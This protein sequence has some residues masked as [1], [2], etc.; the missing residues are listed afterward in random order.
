[1]KTAAGILSRSRFLLFCIAFFD[2]F[3]T[4]EGVMMNKTG[5]VLEGG[6]MRGVYTAGVLDFFLDRSLSFSCCYGASAGAANAC[7]FLSRQRRRGFEIMGD[8]TG[9]RH[10]AGLGSLFRTGNY[11]NHEFHTVT[12]P[13]TLNPFD[14]DTSAKIRLRFSPPSQT[15]L[16]ERLN[17]FRYA[18]CTGTWRQSGLLERFRFCQRKCTETEFPIWTA[19]SQT[20]SRYGLPSAAAP[21]KTSLF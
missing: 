3:F 4:T 9:D 6:G 16:P 5:L 14:Y 13:E 7:S 17:I 19:E 8:Y 1:M 21:C 2:L 10:Y 20:Q 15:A 12:I 11:L 18:I